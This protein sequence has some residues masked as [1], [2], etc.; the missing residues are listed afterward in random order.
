V[1]SSLV[2]TE[3]QIN[4]TLTTWTATTPPTTVTPILDPLTLSLTTSNF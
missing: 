1:W 3:V 4:T 2:V